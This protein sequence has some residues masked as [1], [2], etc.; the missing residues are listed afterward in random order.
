[1]VHDKKSTLC[2]DKGYHYNFDTGTEIRITNDN[3]LE[4]NN[5]KIEL[6]YTEGEIL[7]LLLKN[8]GK[9]IS[10]EEIYEKVWGEPYK[11]ASTNIVMVHILNLRRKIEKLQSDSNKVK[12]IK[13]AW[14][15]GYYIE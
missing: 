6:T 1:M 13:T 10:S 8:R 2:L 15:K 5:R 11:A 14:G 9:I 4:Y 7:H 12:I 3:M